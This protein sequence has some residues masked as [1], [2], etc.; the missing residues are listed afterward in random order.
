MRDELAFARARH[1]VDRRAEAEQPA[2]SPALPPRRLRCAAAARRTRQAAPPHVRFAHQRL[3][4]ERVA[5]LAQARFAS[6]AAGPPH[7]LR[8]HVHARHARGFREQPR[9]LR[10]VERRGSR[11]CTCTESGVSPQQLDR[12]PRAHAHALH[13]CRSGPRARRSCCAAIRGSSTC[14]SASTRRPRPREREPRI[15]GRRSARTSRQLAQRG[16]AA[17]SPLACSLPHAGRVAQLVRAPRL[18]RGGRPFE[19]GRAHPPH[20][21]PSHAP[22]CTAPPAAR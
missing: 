7:A 19:S 22:H 14:A 1:G 16:V 12:R 17:S 20:R 11:R 5:A 15:F 9:R 2:A 3:R 18:H 6:A 8:A 13:R 10:R 4:A 21:S